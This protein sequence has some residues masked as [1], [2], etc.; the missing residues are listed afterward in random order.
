MGH[1]FS[2][3]GSA[4]SLLA[5]F[6]L[7]FSASASL[8]QSGTIRLELDRERLGTLLERDRSPLISDVL[9][10]A[11]VVTVQTERR[12]P[13]PAFPMGLYAFRIVDESVVARHES[14][15]FRASTGRPVRPDEAALPDQRFY[16]A[17]LT[18]DARSFALA[19]EGLAP[20][21]ALDD[22]L[23]HIV[24]CVFPDKPPDWA[25]RQGVYVVA[26]PADS[27]QWR[28]VATFPL[29]LFSD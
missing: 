15:P 5:A 23:D 3:T 28:S 20:A 1:R 11:L 4:A 10:E 24:N 6:F 13:G 9:A 7:L 16:E 2:R 25:K 12:D 17:R 27:R 29:I 22:P 21:S 26:V 18:T 19:D 14:Q 8:A